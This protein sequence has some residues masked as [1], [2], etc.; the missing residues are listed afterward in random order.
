MAF[1]DDIV[2]TKNGR[3]MRCIEYG[4]VMMSVSV[5]MIKVDADLIS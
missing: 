1:M 3:P 5:D 2:F 4:V